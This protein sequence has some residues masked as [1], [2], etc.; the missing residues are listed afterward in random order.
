MK[1]KQIYIK[2]K[3]YFAHSEN[4]MKQEGD[5]LSA[6][7]YFFKMKNKNLFF[8]LKN[9]YS[10]MNNFL[11]KNDRV[12]ELGSGA[13]LLKE[14]INIKIE[15]SDL[16]NQDFINHKNLDAT[17]TKFDNESFDKVISSNLI[18]HIAYPI[19]HFNEVW[20]ILKPNGLYIIQD[21]SCSLM[22]QI[23]INLMRH[24]GYDFS[25]NIY[26]PE[27]QCNNKNDLWSANIAIPNLIFDDFSK[28]N[29]NLNNKFKI[30]HSSKSEFLIF[31]NSGGVIS[32]TI[33]IPLNDF[34]NN[35]V[36]K[37]DKFLSRFDKIFA[38]Q[39]SVVLK[40]TL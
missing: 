16:S 35:I 34:L 30:I 31:L 13:S 14:F 26:D 32:K 4:R 22:C 9:R 27:E 7:E 12:L 5:I 3:S 29:S 18:H 2:K 19:K 36:L 28:F 8:L 39:M 23:I 21:I 20:R 6:R 11:D 10:W 37:I 40:K 25:V 17:N 15:T 24:E 33:N 1:N 38:L